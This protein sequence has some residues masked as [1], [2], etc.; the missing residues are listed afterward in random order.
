MAGNRSMQERYFG[1]RNASNLRLSPHS[2]GHADVLIAAGRVARRSDR[3]A[4]ALAV[5]SVLA[6]DHMVGAHAVADMMAGWLVGRAFQETRRPMR[7]MRAFDVAMAV[8]K[9]WRH[10]A[11]PTC[12][13]HGHPLHLGTPVIDETRECPAC[14]GTGQ[15]PLE[16]LVRT[17]YIEQARW[18][19]GEIDTLCSLVFGEMA[20]E[21]R[22][23]MDLT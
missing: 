2:V 3:K 19:S 22:A 13:G 1:A 21:I 14:H 6:S 4:V 18:L 23:D 8:L 10:P 7:K 20:R 9:W 12:G 15:T 11:C 17:E 5:W 16:R